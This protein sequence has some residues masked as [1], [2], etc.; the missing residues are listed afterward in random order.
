MSWFAKRFSLLSLNPPV[1]EEKVQQIRS[2]T[3]NWASQEDKII[4]FLGVTGSGKSSFI[5]AITNHNDVEVG[6]G[7]CSG[8]FSFLSRSPSSKLLKLTV[9]CF[10]D[11]NGAGFSYNH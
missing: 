7:L 9:V 11:R 3:P 2:S 5:R 1:Q 10:R 8:L 6:H 4:I